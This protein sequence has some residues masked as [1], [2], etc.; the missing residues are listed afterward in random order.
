MNIETLGHASLLI[1]KGNKSLLLTD[2]WFFGTSYWD[3][4]GLKRYPSKSN[5]KDINKVKFAFITHEHQDHLH[6]ETIQKLNK[7]IKYLIP[8]FKHNNIR[9]F[10]KNDKSLNYK[11]LKKEKWYK[12]MKDCGLEINFSKLNL[13]K[14]KDIIEIVNSI[15]IE[16]LNNHPVVLSKKDLYKL[17]E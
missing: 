1:K 14:K 6:P 9:N 2:P 15:N 10:F 17:F 7:K 13:Y 4:W 5:L 8:D 3:S 11:I 12:L 16:R